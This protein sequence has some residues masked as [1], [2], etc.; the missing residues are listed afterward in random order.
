M[1]TSPKPCAGRADMVD[2][3]TR[4]S[5]AHI[6]IG[7]TYIDAVLADLDGGSDPELS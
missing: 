7:G 5:N 6:D 3:A 1:T 2:E 4:A